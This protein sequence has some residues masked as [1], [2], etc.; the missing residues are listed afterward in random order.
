MG[1]LLR[2]AEEDGEVKVG[3]GR[4]FRRARA[5]E[6][7][8]AFFFGASFLELR[9]INLSSF[10]QVYYSYVVNRRVFCLF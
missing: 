2:R 7:N 10:F 9:K 8:P 6:T 4:L 5:C 3:G 1:S